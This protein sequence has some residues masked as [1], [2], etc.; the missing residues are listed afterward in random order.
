VLGRPRGHEQD[1]IVISDATDLANGSLRAVEDA[2]ELL[3]AMG[4]L[5]DPD[6]GPIEVPERF[7][8][9][10]VQTRN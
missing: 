3:A 2:A 9:S 6:T 4:V 1:G 8:G 10:R 7:L 5:E